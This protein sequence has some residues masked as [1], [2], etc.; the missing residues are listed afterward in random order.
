[1]KKI[2][3]PVVAGLFMSVSVHAEDIPLAAQMR[4]EISQACYRA[5]SEVAAKYGNPP[6]S[7]I[8][9][10]DA[11]KGAWLAKAV[12]E[13]ERG[14]SIE[15]LI[16]QKETALKAVES[17]HH[18][19]NGKCQFLEGRVSALND[20]I[21]EKEVQLAKARDTVQ[22]IDEAFAEIYALINEVNADAANRITRATP[23]ARVEPVEQQDSGSV[24]VV[25]VESNPEPVVVAELSP[26][27]QARQLAQNRLAASM[28]KPVPLF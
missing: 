1:M 10:N 12:P 27:E 26:E 18:D 20:E 21:R 7:V 17:R 4:S 8:I 23:K 25:Q 14:Q 6:F 19:L 28:R 2:I 16:A 24:Q 22:R 13:I 11:K 15:E 3:I 9:T 5:A